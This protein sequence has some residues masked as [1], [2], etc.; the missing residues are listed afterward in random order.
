MGRRKYPYKE[1]KLY[2]KSL[3]YELID[4]EYK[5]NNTK[6][7]L[8]DKFGYYYTT[9][10]NSLKSGHLP[11]LTHKNNPYSILNIKLWCKLNNKPFELLSETYEGTYKKLQWKCLKEN[12]SEIFKT[13]WYAILNGNGCGVCEGMQVTLS[14][15]LATKYPKLAKEWHPTKNGDLTPWDVTCGSHKKVWWQC[16]KGHDWKVMIKTR[17]NGNNCPY[18][19]GQ[20]PTKENNLLVINPELCEEWDYEKNKKRPEDYCPNS[21]KKV[22]WKCKECGYEWFALISSRNKSIGCPECCKSKGEKKINEVLI[23]KNWIKISQEDFDNLIDNNKYNKNYFIPQ[24]EFDGL[25]GMGGGLL[26][27]DHYLPK[28]NLL[29]EYQGEFHDGTAKQQ[30]EEEYEIQI[31]HDR[32]K[33]EY[34]QNNNIKLLEIWY[35]DFDRIEEILNIIIIIN[36]KIVVDENG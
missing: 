10:L 22:W 11:N 2:I 35:W 30:T 12:C 26:S 36:N 14:N 15:C 33:C 34:A 1:V 19:A 25:I 21:N 13:A 18:C 17:T 16:S 9:T 24:K 8:I 7:T 3:G 4:E 32:R 31:E 20:L 28:L 5:N 6:L 27:Y 29:I 23:N